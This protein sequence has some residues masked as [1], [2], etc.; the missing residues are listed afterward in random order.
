MILL[1]FSEEEKELDK[2]N[3]LS[4]PDPNALLLSKLY[5]GI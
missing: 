1:L 2:S 4:K 5:H 3:P